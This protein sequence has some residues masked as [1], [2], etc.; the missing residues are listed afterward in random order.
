MMMSY[1]ELLCTR[2]SFI[3]LVLPLAYCFLPGQCSTACL[4]LAYQEAGVV[5]NVA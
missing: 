3:L 5:P 2:T 4:E 1:C